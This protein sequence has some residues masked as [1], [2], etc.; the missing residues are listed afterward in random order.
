MALNGLGEIVKGAAL[1]DLAGLRGG[2]QTGS[3]EFPVGAAIAEADLA[4]LYGDAQ[5]PLRAV[6]GGFYSRLLQERE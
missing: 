3:G 2:E 5:S 1:L 4:P 6:I